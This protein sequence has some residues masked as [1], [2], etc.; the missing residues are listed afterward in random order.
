LK[1]F[2]GSDGGRIV[3][4]TSGLRWPSRMV[5]A[6]MFVGG[7]LFTR[8][9]L[10]MNLTLSMVEVRAGAEVTASPRLAILLYKKY[11]ESK[12]C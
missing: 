12:D 2:L 5:S 3:K 6:Y 1:R 9:A 8:S 11:E 7:V 4:R 10:A